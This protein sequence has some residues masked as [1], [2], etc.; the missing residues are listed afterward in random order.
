MNILR[1]NCFFYMDERP[2]GLADALRK[3][4]DHVERDTEPGNAHSIGFTMSSGCSRWNADLGWRLTAQ[5]GLFD[6]KFASIPL[7]VGQG[8]AVQPGERIDGWS[9]GLIK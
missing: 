8:I 9:H 1:L 5:V 7:Q 2:A 3:L 4:A 6:E